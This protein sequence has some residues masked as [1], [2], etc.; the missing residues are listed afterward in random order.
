VKLTGQFA[1]Q[2]RNLL[3]STAGAGLASN[4]LEFLRRRHLNPVVAAAL[5]ETFAA[6]DHEN[7]RDVE[8]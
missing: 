2:P 7:P 4:P 1:S 8:G 6:D 3:A 5:G